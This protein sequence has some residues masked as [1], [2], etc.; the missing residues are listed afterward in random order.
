MRLTGRIRGRV[1]LLI[2]ACACLAPS[3]LPAEALGAPSVAIIVNEQNSASDLSTTEVTQIL[4]LQRQFW[5][6]GRRIVLILPAPG[7]EARDVIL[8][9]IYHRP[10]DAIRKEW[11][12][13]LFAGEIAALPSVAKSAAAAAAIVKQVPGAIAIVLSTEVQPGVKALAI[14][15]KRPG[16]DGYPLAAADTP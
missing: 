7:S 12:R 3:A 15:A 9:T 6:D 2:T 13:K 4:A 1:P 11:A 8:V 14:D 5:K 16:E 10:E